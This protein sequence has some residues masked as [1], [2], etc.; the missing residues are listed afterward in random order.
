MKI[1]A[2]SDIH[3]NFSGF[4]DLPDADILLI[5]GDLT[6]FGQHV[7]TPFLTRTNVNHA[8]KKIKAARAWMQNLSERYP[9]ILWVQ[10]NHDCAVP[11]D[12][13]FDIP[14]VQNIRKKS[15]ELRG[16]RFYGESLCTAFDIPELATVW[17]FTTA[18]P[19][20]DFAAWKDVAPA[21]VIVSHCP[22]LG[23]ADRTRQGMRI[24]SP[25]LLSHLR[26]H[27]AL[28]VVCGHVH[29]AQ[30]EYQMGDTRVLNV[31]QTMQLFELE[32]H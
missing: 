27:P 11:D 7:P 12:L 8:R 26:K 4:T 3:D 20:V 24:G 19:A 31:A 18:D 1:L 25:G 16:L 28:V 23:V 30:G 29:E 32:G 9:H 15:L 10:G 21:D 22:P 6:N 14:N 17:D 2:I 5:A 13:F